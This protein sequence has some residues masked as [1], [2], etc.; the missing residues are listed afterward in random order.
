MDVAKY[1]SENYDHFKGTQLDANTDYES[2]TRTFLR[3]ILFLNY[4]AVLLEIFINKLNV[5]L[6]YICAKA[7]ILLHQFLIIHFKLDLQLKLGC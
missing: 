4:V 5:N 1:N 2:I 3:L 7:Y 6:D